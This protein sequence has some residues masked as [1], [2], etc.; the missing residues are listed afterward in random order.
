R[1]AGVRRPLNLI[2]AELGFHVS[3]M[4]ANRGRVGGNRLELLE[5]SQAAAQVAVVV[6]QFDQVGQNL[7]AGVFVRLFFLGL[8]RVP[9][10]QGQFP[11][12]AGAFVIVAIFVVEAAQF[13]KKLVAV[14][15]FLPAFT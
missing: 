15:I 12:V 3:D 7:F 11:N 14:G 8:L 6:F 5:I 4:L 10:F 1:T 2:N 9:L 13:E